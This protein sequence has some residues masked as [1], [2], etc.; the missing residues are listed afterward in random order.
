MRAGV[1]VSPHPIRRIIL[2]LLNRLKQ[3][4]TQPVIAH[5]TVITFDVRILLRVA[6]LNKIQAYLLFCPL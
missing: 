1:I 4:M 2:H 3:V 5:R 6:R